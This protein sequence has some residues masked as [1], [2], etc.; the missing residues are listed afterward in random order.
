MTG[1]ELIGAVLAPLVGIAVRVLSNRRVLAHQ[2][3]AAE[4]RIKYNEALSRES[5]L[6]EKC[7]SCAHRPEEG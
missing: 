3:E 1:I 5:S 4:L 6:R 7:A 2:E